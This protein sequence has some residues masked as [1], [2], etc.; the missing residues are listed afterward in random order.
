MGLFGKMKI[1]DMN[2]DKSSKDNDLKELNERPR[3]CCLDLDQSVIDKLQQSKFNIYSGILGEKIRVPNKNEYSSHQ[4]LL[5]NDF[6][7]NIHEYDIF[8]IDLGNDKIIDYN[9]DEHIRKNHTG[10]TAISLLSSYPETI[11]NPKPLSSIILNNEIK[12]IGD[13]PFMLIVFTTSS[14][15]VEYETIK[16][17]VRGSSRQ[18]GQK[19]NIYS[20]LDFVPLSAS[21]TGKELLACNMREDLKILLKS[22]LDGAIY[23]QTFYHPTIWKNDERVPNNK[24]VP[25]LTNSSND[26]VSYCEFKEKS[27]FF[28]FPQLKSKA[29]FLN[30]F[31]LNIAPE[32]L[33]D[34]FPFSTKFSWKNNEDYWVP[35]HKKLLNEKIEIENEYKRKLKEKETQIAN[36][37]KKYEFLHNII[38]D[39]GD[40]LV[41]ALAIYF[42]WLGF[43]KVI[44]VDKT[45][46]KADV[47]EE[48][49]QI[50]L[51]N[52]LLIIECKG[53]GGT[54]TD[55]D[56]S[57]I[58]KIKY[59]RS[60]ERG[61]FDVFALY[62]VNHQRYLPPLNRRNPP[63][64]KN[65]IEDAQNDE[66]GLLSTWQL[67]NLYFDIENG[68]I[69]KE[70]ARKTLLNY[71]LVEFKP[72]N[73]IYIDEPNEIL[74][75]GEV[76]IVNISNINL[77][78]GEELILEKNGQFKKANIESIQL[79]GK[80]VSFAN[81]GEIGLKLN[82][83]I[84]KK[85]KLWKKASS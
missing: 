2:E 32:L 71:G 20:F 57:Q 51:D 30:E 63:F 54:S 40:N 69:S 13:R 35:K 80:P 45:K 67:F 25:L 19:Y 12:Q 56:C 70:E 22:N 17:T 39:T 83:K 7:I 66:R 37:I 27:I 11:F 21:K 9:S 73:L 14:Y 18:G 47:L 16:I 46:T 74:K 43:S 85:T 55:S 72:K 41:E 48:D 15:E 31:L 33:P 58:S 61:K 10:K 77:S 53:I 62:I 60:K 59:R 50:E 75:N 65:Q 26:I 8:I 4:V 36:N 42:K 79:N 49:I 44:N 78:I 28:F 38:T 81:N 34:I 68:I 64:T 6:P 82:T 3:V 5:Q 24:F 23:N 1:K 76:C 52:G 29:E 84:K